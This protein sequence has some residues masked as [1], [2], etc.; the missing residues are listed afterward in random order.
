MR[1]RDEMF[2]FAGVTVLLTM[3]PVRIEA[4]T[5]SYKGNIAAIFKKRCTKCHGFLL[6]Q[7]GL[8][9]NS[10]KGIL[11]GGESGAAVLPGNPDGSLLYRQFFL[12]AADPRRMPP[13]AE[14][15]ELTKAEISKIKA[16]IA[17]GAK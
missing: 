2:L 8:K 7:K 1:L 12:P 11:K 16:W 17:G 4:E 3:A 6:P 13:A 14:K 10:L 15:N 9:L 5:A